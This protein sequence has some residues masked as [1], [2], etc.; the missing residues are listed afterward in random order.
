M[1]LGQE[2]DKKYLGPGNLNLYLSLFLQLLHFFKQLKA[3]ALVL[4]ILGGKCERLKKNLLT[5]R[6]GAELCHQCMHIM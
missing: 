5:E 3:K 4:G 1:D 6:G 2:K